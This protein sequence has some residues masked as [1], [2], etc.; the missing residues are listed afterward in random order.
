MTATLKAEEQL[1]AARAEL[2]E[3]QLATRQALNAYE[4]AHNQT[5]ALRAE[6]AASCKERDALRA[7]LELMDEGMCANYDT[8]EGRM[9]GRKA[10]IACRSALALCNRATDGENK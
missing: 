6:L 3:Y 4:I 2:K 7:A 9:L 8:R 10:L 1:A 5:V